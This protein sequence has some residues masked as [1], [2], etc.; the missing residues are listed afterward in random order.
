MNL[1]RLFLLSCLLAGPAFAESEMPLTGESAAI[2]YFQLAEEPLP[3]RSMIL[4][5]SS[6]RFENEFDRRAFLDEQLSPYSLIVHAVEQNDRFTTNVSA[7][8]GEY[9]FAANAFP[10]EGIHESTYY[11]PRG[12]RGIYGPA[13]AV[14]IVNSGEFR[15]LEMAPDAARA[16]LE[17]LGGDKRVVLRFVVRPLSSEQRD[18]GGG[19]GLTVY[20]ALNVHAGSAVIRLREGNTELARLQAG[21]AFEDHDPEPRSLTEIDDRLIADPWA[22]AWSSR[23]HLEALVAHYDLENWTAFERMQVA[24][25][26][27][28]DFGYTQCQRLIERRRQLALRCTNV[29]DED[30]LCW[31]IQGLPYTPAEGGRP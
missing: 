14:H 10:L 30:R 23:E 27:V 11:S 9:D 17:R 26:C 22:R 16:L 25:P 20:R 24:S 31:R 28:S 2:L 3:L 13:L 15:Q 5:S 8:I 19:Q 21:S 18:F 7:R 4:A 12:T 1:F 29:L 6:S